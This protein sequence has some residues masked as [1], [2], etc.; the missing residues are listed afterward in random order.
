ML[1][2]LGLLL[3]LFVSVIVNAQQ[4]HTRELLQGTWFLT[5]VNIEPLFYYPGRD[6]CTTDLEADSLLSLEFKRDTLL[7]IRHLKYSKNDTT[8]FIW[9]MTERIIKLWDPNIKRK[10]QRPKY[11]H[12]SSLSNFELEITESIHDYSSVLTSPIHNKMTFEKSD[13]RLKYGLQR[14]YYGDWFITNAK[15]R[16]FETLVN[17]QTIKLQRDTVY[18]DTT[19]HLNSCD[20]E[21]YKLLEYRLLSISAMGQCRLI[22]N[23]DTIQNS[24]PLCNPNGARFEDWTYPHTAVKTNSAKIIIYQKSREIAITMSDNTSHLFKYERIGQYLLLIKTE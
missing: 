6:Y 11:F 4:R 23:H 12:I 1:K 20:I 14:F 21:E 2:R 22:Q 7:K 18:L 24:V 13:E 16:N 10:K 8:L 17:L 5:S 3:L 15:I 19:T 9:E